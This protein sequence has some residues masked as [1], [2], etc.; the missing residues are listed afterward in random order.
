MV[1][2]IE[3]QNGARKHGYEFDPS[4]DRIRELTAAIRSNWSVEERKRRAS[5]ARYVQIN[6]IP[7]WPSRKA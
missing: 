3:K 6:H 4:P 2:F 1:V 7:L 5:I